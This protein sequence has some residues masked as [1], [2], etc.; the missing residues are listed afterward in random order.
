MSIREQQKEALYAKCMLIRGGKPCPMV[1]MGTS[2]DSCSCAI[3][4][5]PDSCVECVNQKEAI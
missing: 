4:E 1:S 2:V 5:T 3:G